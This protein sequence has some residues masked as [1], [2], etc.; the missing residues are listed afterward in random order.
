MTRTLPGQTKFAFLKEMDRQLAADKE[1]E[2]EYWRRTHAES[3]IKSCLERYPPTAEEWDIMLMGIRLARFV[4]SYEECRHCSLD[5][6]DHTVGWLF[7]TKVCVKDYRQKFRQK[8]GK[9]DDEE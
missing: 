6:T 1:A 9:T 5:T 8:G 3:F 2:A 4:N 7:P